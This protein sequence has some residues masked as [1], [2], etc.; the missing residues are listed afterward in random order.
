M[1]STPR[2]G[3]LPIKEGFRAIVSAH[4]YIDAYIIYAY[5]CIYIHRCPNA[6]KCRVFVP[7]S[8]KSTSRP[9][10]LP[11]KEGFRAIVSAYIYIDAYIIYAYICIIYT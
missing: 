9:G 8:S 10:V 1:G 7:I 5:I 11:I 6:R 3:V 2:P 4:I